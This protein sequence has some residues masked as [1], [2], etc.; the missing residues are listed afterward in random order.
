MQQTECGVFPSRAEG[1]NLDALEMLSCGKYVIATDY[2]AHTQ[3]LT[4]DNSLLVPINELEP[5]HDG[6]WFF[7]QGNWSKLNETPM[8]QLI[9][10]LQTVHKCKQLGILVLNKQGIET[11]NIFTWKNTANSIIHYLS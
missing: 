5:A 8:L 2:S 4:K 1:W 6:V 10:H 3:F 9:E 7:G 11:A